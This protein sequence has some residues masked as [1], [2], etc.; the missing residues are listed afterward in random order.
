MDRIADF[1]NRGVLLRDDE[2]EL[3]KIGE[4][5]SEFMTA[6]PMPQF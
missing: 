2:A 4:E 5:V 3:R 6:F 1:I